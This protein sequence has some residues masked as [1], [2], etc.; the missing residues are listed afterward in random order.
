MGKFNRDDRSSGSRGGRSDGSRPAMHQAVCSDCGKTCEVP[1]RPTGDRPVY[2]A[3]CFEKRG[4]VNPVSTRPG[5]NDKRMFSAV[6]V[7]CGKKCEVPFRPSGNKPVYCSD[8]FKLG[9][10]AK[11]QAPAPSHDG[12]AQI[13]AK[14]DLILKVLAP[15]I[16]VTAAAK[17]AAVLA[18]PKKEV[19]VKAAKPKA[20]K[21]SPAKK[22]KK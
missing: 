15:K 18:K 17:P 21:K 2:C 5:S 13:N 1:F 3:A 10:A 4:H 22:K 16:S 19:K 9:S 20:V 7:N 11:S 14:L 8:C 6:C 12:L